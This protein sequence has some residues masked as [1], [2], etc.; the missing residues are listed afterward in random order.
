MT[1]GWTRLLKAA[2]WV[3]SLEPAAWLVWAA[4]GGHF[5]A[6]PL[7]DITHL[8]GD[9]ALRFL[10]ITLAITP[11]RRLTGWNDLVRFRRLMGL[12]AFFYATLHL[13]TWVVFDRAGSLDYPNGIVS[14]TT[15]RGLAMATAADVYK[16]PFITMGMTA[17][18]CLLLLA[19][20]STAGWIRRLGGKR[21]QALHRLIYPAAIAGV[22]HYL[23]LVKSDI[24]RPIAYGLV[25]AA[26]LGFRV[27]WSRRK[28]PAM[29]RPPLPV[30]QPRADL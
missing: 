9:W 2:L 29:R 10:C 17:L 12:F 26:L 3:A 28:A 27:V 11:L 24:S 5:S 19:A 20:S 6:D 18:T 14:W 23:W 7:A 8:T 21:W 25:V 30:P 16:R 22:I 1:R 13:L 4:Y 15:V